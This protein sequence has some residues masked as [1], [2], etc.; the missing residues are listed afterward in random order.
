MSLQE[1]AA[2][3]EADD[4]WRWRVWAAENGK[5]IGASTEAYADRGAAES[6]LCRLTHSALLPVL[7]TK[8]RHAV[9]GSTYLLVP[10]LRAPEPGR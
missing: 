3:Y 2:V 1:N 6:N 5:I 8:S 7:E 9:R 10:M 4:G